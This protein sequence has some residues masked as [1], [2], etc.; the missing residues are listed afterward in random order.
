MTCFLRT[1]IV[2][3]CKLIHYLPAALSTRAFKQ[4]EDNAHWSYDGRSSHFLRQN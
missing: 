4:N 1:P 3:C 2:K